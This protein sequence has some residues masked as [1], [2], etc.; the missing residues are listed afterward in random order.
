M[1]LL[2]IMDF[3]LLLAITIVSFV[4]LQTPGTGLMTQRLA[5]KHSL[6]CVS[7]YGATLDM[8]YTEYFF[9]V[10][11]QVVRVEEDFVLL[12]DAYIL[13][14][15][16]QGTP[17]FSTYLETR[18]TF[19]D[20]HSS[21]TSPK[22]VLDNVDIRTSYPNNATNCHDDVNG[23]S[24]AALD[25]ILESPSGLRDDQVDGINYKDDTQRMSTTLPL[26]ATSP[27]DN[28]I[29]EIK[30]KNVTPGVTTTLARTSISLKDNC[31]M[32]ALSP[33]VLQEHSLNQDDVRSND[34]NPQTLPRSCSQEDIYRD[35]PAGI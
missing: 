13:F 30:D 9:I 4:L 14:Y 22:S 8:G 27:I 15:A 26:G 12:Q 24:Y 16:K 18:K 6:F 1:Q 25:N 23:T 3:L 34:D 35:E 32:K 7:C 10:A 33:S 28:S 20:P 19:L 31:D 21:N 17:W 29:D 2:C 5:H 11:L